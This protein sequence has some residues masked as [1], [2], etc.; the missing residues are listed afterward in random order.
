MRLL[1]LDHVVHIQIHNRFDHYLIRHALSLQVCIHLDQ[2]ASHLWLSVL[3]LVAHLFAEEL[4]R[5]VLRIF[6]L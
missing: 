5:E 4:L 2:Y 1:T 3:R 6:F